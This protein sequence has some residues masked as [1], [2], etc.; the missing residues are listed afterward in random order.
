MKLESKI[1]QKQIE[2]DHIAH[3]YLF[4]GQ[5][6][7]YVWEQALLFAKEA[8][9]ENSFLKEKFDGGQLADVLVIEA[10]KN[11]ISI[12]QIRSIKTFLSTM[13][14]ESNRKIILIKDC[15]KMR[16]ESANALLKTL[17][18]SPDY[19]LL[20][21]TTALKDV[22]LKTIVSRCQSIDF[23]G[24]DM[25]EYSFDLHELFDILEKSLQRDLLQMVFA[26]GFFEREKDHKEEIIEGILLFFVDLLRFIST[27]NTAMLHFP[28]NVKRY[29][30]FREMKDY[31]IENI[32]KKV[33]QIGYNFRYNINYQLSMEELL[34]YIMEENDA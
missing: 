34:L 9:G 8:V 15:E 22:L 26:R 13:P 5:D 11:I 6:S 18:E 27:K 16:T 30:M 20:I 2:D 21:L 1:L 7:S 17:E 28:Q 24:S 14:L 23:Y 4:C 32:I 31:H 19:A 3:A 33:N 29:E 25:K 10:E 12:E